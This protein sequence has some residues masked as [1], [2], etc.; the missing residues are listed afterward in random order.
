MY[1][2]VG[3]KLG[4]A[5]NGIMNEVEAAAMW[6]N[7]GLLDYQALVV[8]KHLQCKFH[9]NKI[10]V[11]FQKIFT[12]VEGYTKLQVKAFEYHIEGEKHPEMV[13]AQ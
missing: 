11:P 5:V 8:L 4:L 2:A 9:P 13:I 10:T 3:Q 7:A 12:I 6:H 1:T